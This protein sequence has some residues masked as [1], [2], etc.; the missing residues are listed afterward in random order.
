[1][2]I[3][4]VALPSLPPRVESM[5]APT[6]DGVVNPAGFSSALVAQ[7]ELLNSLKTA[8]L[9][10]VQTVDGVDLP[11]VVVQSAV[12]DSP[13]SMV[14]VQE[15]ATLV[16]NDLPIS[17]KV[18]DDAEHDATLAAVTDTLKYMA[19]TT[20]VEKS[21][22]AEQNIKAVIAMAAPLEQSTVEAGRAVGE[23]VVSEMNAV[24]VADTEQSAGDAEASAN[25][26]ATIETGLDATAMSN[27]PVQMDFGR[28]KG[29]D[30]DK[31]KPVE[32]EA[33]VTDV[34][35]T[36]ESD[37]LRAAMASPVVMAVGQERVV[38]NLTPADADGDAAV[39]SV[40]L[41]S[42]SAAKPMAAEKVS[43]DVLRGEAVF[44]QLEQDKQGFTLKNLER[45]GQTEKSGW[46][47]TL[48][49]DSEGGKVLSKVD[50]TGL[51]RPVADNKQDVPAITKPLS[52]PEWNKDLGERIVW[53]SSK[54][55]PSAE[56]RLNPQH[57]GPISVRVNVTDDQAT[58]VFTAQHAAVRETIEASI[59]KLREMMSSQQLNLVEASVSQGATSDQ[60]RSQAQSFSQGFS[61]GR[62]QGAAGAGV[63]AMSEV[64]QEIDSGRAVVSKGVLSLY[65]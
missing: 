8:E 21:A 3:E 55:I 6:V 2:N 19:S 10:P 28:E 9:L 38:N 35:L 52:H 34:G 44:R 59:P 15:I 17:Y 23:G 24:A 47:D 49:S 46:T 65:A 12:A 51:N 43:G 61:D 39:Q 13:Q 63:D 32:D 56:I 41:S 20:A 42:V 30:K 22:E 54:A 45:P 14:D 37:A 50:A 62:G 60:G 4:S 11:T 40:L 1:M 58:V 29:S 7:I 16:G 5:T 31:E 64:E 33:Q 27:A 53:M 18:E 25:D 57:L 26:A 36:H 48:V